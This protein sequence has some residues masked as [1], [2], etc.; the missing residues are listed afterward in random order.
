M[1]LRLAVHWELPHFRAVR[2]LSGHRDQALAIPVPR[3]AGEP[4]GIP[5][6]TM[7]RSTGRGHHADLEVGVRG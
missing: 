6:C 7:T 1:W 5:G 2:V 3:E 4:P